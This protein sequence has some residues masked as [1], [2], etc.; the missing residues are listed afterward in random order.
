M[1]NTTQSQ[2]FSIDEAFNCFEITFSKSSKSEQINEAQKRLMEMDK[3]ILENLKLFLGGI[4]LKD[5]YS[6]NLKLS[7]LIYMKNS[8]DG[9]IKRK[10]LTEEHIWIIIKYFIDF[11]ISSND[12]TDK[13]IN[14]TNSLLQN[15]FNWKNIVKDSS[16][17]TELF[18][19]IRNYLKTHID[20]NQ[21]DDSNFNIG[22]FKRLI[23]LMQMLFATKSINDNNINNIFEL[24]LNIV[25]LIFLK[26][27]NII[28]YIIKNVSSGNIILQK[29]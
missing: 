22:V 15:L 25:D 9:K 12:L 17:T 18:N 20:Q 19:M 14:N 8:I 10:E 5:R 1:S 3:N 29:Y 21:N 13:I 6:E 28:S 24:T 7:V 2:P 23:S 11:L 27:Q 26:N 4:S 16:A